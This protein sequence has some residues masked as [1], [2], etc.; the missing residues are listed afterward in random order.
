[1]IRDIVFNYLCIGVLTIYTVEEM[2]WRT[3]TFAVANCG[4]ICFSY[5]FIYI[6]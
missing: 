1:V 3:K 2:L 5:Y 6:M 4:L